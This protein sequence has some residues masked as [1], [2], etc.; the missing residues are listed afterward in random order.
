MKHL[1]IYENFRVKKLL[2]LDDIRD[3]HKNQE[4]LVFSPIEQPFEVIWVMDHDEF[5]NWI[6]KN[7]LPDG[8]SY[9]YDLG[10]DKVHIKKT[11]SKSAL[12]RFRKTDEYL[13]GADCARFLVDYC[14][15]HDLDIPPFNIHSANKQGKVEISQIL[16]DVSK[17]Q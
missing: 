3:P 15:E 5:K 2:W 6:I 13:N 16:G 14:K 10:L 17:F 11:M 8:I 12:K 4:W 1:Q 9:D 7:G